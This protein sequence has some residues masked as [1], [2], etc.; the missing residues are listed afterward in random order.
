MDYSNMHIDIR[1]NSE[2]EETLKMT[3]GDIYFTYNGIHI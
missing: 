2:S 1:G 3:P